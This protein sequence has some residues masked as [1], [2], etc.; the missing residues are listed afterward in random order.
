MPRSNAEAL[1]RD[2]I[3]DTL[4]V[5]DKVESIY[6]T[7]EIERNKTGSPSS[8]R[9]PAVRRSKPLKPF[10]KKAAN[11]EIFVQT[12]DGGFRARV[13]RAGTE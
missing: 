3:G 9:A 4:I 6:P 11:E 5:P 13:L 2:L 1:Y 12:A 10:E 7:T 8:P